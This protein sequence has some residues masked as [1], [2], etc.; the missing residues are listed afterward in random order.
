VTI[1]GVLIWAAVVLVIAVP[2]FVAAASPWLEYRRPIYIAGGFAGIAGLALLL[3]Q[4]LLAVGV[5]P[6]LAG[7][8]GRRVHRATGVLL[9]A[10]VALH[11]VGLWI[12]SPPD[13]IDV[14][15]LRS[16]T[17][18]SLWGVAAMWAVF[19]AGVL[20]VMRRRLRPRVW[21]RMHIA[22]V[23]VIVAGTVV[24]AML[25]E[26]AMGVVS[27]A[28]LCGVVVVVSGWALVKRW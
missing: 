25:I 7:V 15:L 21:R 28:V 23:V 17:P 8:H 26:G 22:L 20:A 2:V 24:H 11:V 1:R 10:A 4:P 3:V 14:L 16:P 5:L 9:V 12:T 6:G 27:K 13:V 18:F 19:A